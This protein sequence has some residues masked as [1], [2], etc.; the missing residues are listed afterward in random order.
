MLNLRNLFSLIIVVFLS[1]PSTA[2]SN[3][4]VKAQGRKLM[5]KNEEFL[6]KGICFSN[7]YASI[8]RPEDLKTSTHHSAKDFEEIAEMGLNAVRFAFRG[9]WYVKNPQVFFAWIDQN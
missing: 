6:L 3:A 7:E 9:D 5:L 8:Q 2:Q 1:A 4:F